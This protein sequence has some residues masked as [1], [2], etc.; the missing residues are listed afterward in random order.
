MKLNPILLIMAA[1]LGIG[2]LIGRQGGGK[3]NFEP[4]RDLPQLG[5]TRAAGRS[6]RVDPFGGPSFSLSSLEDLRGLFKSQSAN[7]ASAR[8]TLAATALSAEEIPALMEMVQKEMRENPYGDGP[9]W[10]LMSVLFERWATVDPAASIAFVHDC[11]SRSFQKIAATYCYDALAKADPARAFLE[12]KSLPKGEIREL[13]SQSIVAELSE[14]DPAAACDLL[15][16]ESNP[17]IFGDYSRGYIL[18]AWA[19]KDPVAAAARFEK[20]PQDQVGHQSAGQ[21]TAVWAQTDPEA[22]LKWAKT[23]RG[24]LKISASAEVYKVLARKNPQA[25]WEKIKGEPG[26]MRAKIASGILEVVVDDDPKIAMAMLA[27]I[28]NKSEQRIAT[29]SFLGRL[30]WNDS[31]I[32]FELIDQVKDPATRRE[33][34]ANQLY[35]ATYNSPALL[36]EQIGKLSEREKIDTSASVLS[37]LVRSDP[38]A[39]ERYFLALPEA[40]R[41][42]Y[43]LQN[44]LASYAELDPKKGLA[45]ASALKNPQEQSA[46]VTGLFGKWSSDDPEAAADGWKKLPAGQSRLEALDQVATSWSTSDPEAAE[47][48]ANSL[49][50]VE[51]TRALIAVLPAMVRDNPGKAS[52]QLAALIST[53]GD[54]MGKNL[55]NAASTL[56]GQWANDEPGAAAKW[57]AALPSGQ[58]RDAGLTAVSASWSQYDAIAT[59]QWLGTLEVGASRDAAIQPLVT[60]V[61]M[62]DPSTAFSW[63]ASIS[64]ETERL[65][66]MRQTLSSWRSS[67]LTGARAALDAADVSPAAREK[68]LK[69]VN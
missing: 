68:L 48:W 3:D 59:A 16:I 31:K 18:A 19:K 33:N 17:R 13:V 53:P 41:G 40:Q 69:E 28:G 21:L 6:Q 57:A 60:Q 61:R 32:A 30:N 43:T 8:M 20:M 24:E 56:A 27:S 36:K 52:S 42:A 22:A 11:K 50:G 14:R 7:V 9:E 10:Q 64:D 65:E 55:A 38:G 58:S 39:A 46:A 5:E 63:A 15:E 1:A 49:T 54:G 4:R 67:D 45:F 66:Q 51:R 44:M 35:Y 37:G 26:H 25:A 2:F 29:G 47:K 62:S 34:L 12:F 23:L